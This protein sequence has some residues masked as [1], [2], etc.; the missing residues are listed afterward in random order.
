MDKKLKRRLALL[1]D[2][3]DYALRGDCHFK[4]CNGPEAPIR[5]MRTC[6]RCVCI[7]RALQMG[8]VKKVENSYVK[9]TMRGEILVREGVLEQF[10]AIDGVLVD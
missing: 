10:S 6:S 5:H 4:F 3:L 8:L 9:N 1:D 2:L 7:H